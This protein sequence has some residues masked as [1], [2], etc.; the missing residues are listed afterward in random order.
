LA[1]LRIL[2]ARRIT[3]FGMLVGE[4]S[5]LSALGGALGLG[6]GHLLVAATAGLV[7]KNSGVHP[8]ALVVLPEELLAYVLLVTAGAVA[9]LVPA[10]KAYRTDAAAQ[11]APLV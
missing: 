11:L 6:L 4:A 2:G 8:S 9:G 5:L 7:A 3:I 10:A 1:I